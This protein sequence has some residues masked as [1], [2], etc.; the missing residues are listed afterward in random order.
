MNSNMIGSML[1]ALRGPQASRAS[2]K[3][4]YISTDYLSDHKIPFDFSFAD[5][6]TKLILPFGPAIDI[7][8]LTL[9]SVSEHQDTYPVTSLGNFGIKGMTTGHLLVAGTL[10]FNVLHENPFAE[11]IKA[12]SDWKGNNANSI[13][14]SPLN[15]PPFDLNILFTNS[16]GDVSYLALRAVKLLDSGKNVSVQ[17]IRLTDVYSFMAASQTTLVPV[18][19][20]FTAPDQTEKPQDDKKTQTPSFFQSKRA[21]S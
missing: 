4:S 20:A 16:N 1:G 9:I 3:K 7:Y 2:S 15:L 18:G 11:A 21:P 17:D 14:I 19:L 12:Y 13:W 6:K 10:A 8:G 5:V